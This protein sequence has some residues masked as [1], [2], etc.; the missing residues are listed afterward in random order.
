MESPVLFAKFDSSH[1]YLALVVRAL[2][3]HQIKVQS[4]QQSA[5]QLNT[6]FT[7]SKSTHVSVIEWI[8]DSDFPTI[9]LGTTGG[10]VIIY[11][12]VSNS[13]VSEFDTQLNLGITD[14][15]YSKVTKSL[16]CSDNGGNLLE[17]EIPAGEL[18]SKFS[19]NDML[20][21]AESI[22]KVTTVLYSGQ[23]H[24]LVGTHNVYLIDLSTKAIVKTFPGHV[25]PIN[26]LLPIAAD[27][28]LFVTAA[29]GDRFSNVYSLSKGTNKAVLVAEG[30][31]ECVT[32]ES[33]GSLSIMA[34][35]SESGNIELFNNP[36][37]F[38]APKTPEKSKK[39][40]KHAAATVQSRH[41]DA[42]IKFNR[43]EAEIR[44]PQDESLHINTVSASNDLL[45]VTWLEGASVSSFDVLRWL[46]EY[47]FAFQGTLKIEK[48]KKKI[49]ASTHTEDGQDVA[50][51]A[52]YRESQTVITEGN[53]YHADLDEDNE[54]DETL[55]ERA[56][57]LKEEEG[58]EKE[59]QRKKL[60]K[61]TSGSLA[62]VLTQALQSNDQPM[63]ESSVL[64]SRD[65]IIIQ[66]TI[67]R[68]SP[69]LAITLLDKLTEKITRKQRR[70]DELYY[71]IRWV[72]II[73]GG[74]L[75]LIPNV[76]NKLANLH[77]ILSKKADGLPRLLELKGR[78][79][80][81]QQQKGLKMEILNGRPSNEK[82]DDESEVEYIEELDD[83]E[84]AG[85][86]MSDDDMDDDDML[87]DDYDEM[88]DM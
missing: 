87:V 57:K 72:V 30:A 81:L 73:H 9:A 24:L 77:S 49:Q 68:L 39:K 79:N 12:P 74:V 60:Q 82:E 1:S 40:R 75:S 25:Q 51:P 55:A 17:W 33:L 26:T 37:A 10:R 66:N 41:A 3:V 16:W 42:I 65:P 32:V 67:A 45:Y 46:N 31:V 70:F 64:L 15:H 21:S 27:P 6:S 83:A 54:D 34:V 22:Y 20:D 78:L 13:I 19:L 5:D 84:H 85:V 86:A 56:Q 59:E 11:S 8:S 80:L 50:A 48:P 23:P 53:A 63:L 2:D 14:V 44:N 47:G 69:T 52:L 61:H 29:D 76:S 88:E 4:I 58:G 36:L 43:P 18:M 28:D 38:D 35:V 7:C 62:I 71:W